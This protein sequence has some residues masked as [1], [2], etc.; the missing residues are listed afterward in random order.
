MIAN[1]TQ[2]LQISTYIGY[3]ILT[4]GN[5]CGFYGNDIDVTVVTT[6][7]VGMYF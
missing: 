5:Y 6:E 1:Y 2:V 4:I 7:S 3:S